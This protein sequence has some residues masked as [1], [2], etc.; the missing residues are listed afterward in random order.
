MMHLWRHRYMGTAL[1]GLF[2]MPTTLYI[3]YCGLRDVTSH[4][5]AASEKHVDCDE[6][7]AAKVYE[8]I[9]NRGVAQ[10]G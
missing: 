4:E 8:E 1:E 9:D 6:C 2:R 7:F 3:T 5:V 10:S